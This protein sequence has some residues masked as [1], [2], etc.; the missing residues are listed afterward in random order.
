MSPEDLPK[1]VHGGVALLRGRKAVKICEEDKKVI[2]EDGTT[3]GYD[4]LLI[5]TGVRPKK[6]QVFEEASEEAKQK[7]TYF[8]YVS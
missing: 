3:I 1:A 7:I 8:H 6:E 2:L 4:K 5:A